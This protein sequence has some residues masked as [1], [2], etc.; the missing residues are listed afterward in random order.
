MSA[1]DVIGSLVGIFLW[2]VLIGANVCIH[3][4]RRGWLRVAG[5]NAEK[6]GEAP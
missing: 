3:G 4:L 2:G 5:I 1:V 6:D